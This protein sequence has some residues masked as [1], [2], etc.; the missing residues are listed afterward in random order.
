M[1]RK[2]GLSYS[3]IRKLSRSRKPPR[4]PKGTPRNTATLIRAFW[5]I[6]K[7]EKLSKPQFE[8]VRQ[9]R[10]YTKGKPRTKAEAELREHYSDYLQRET[11]AAK[12]RGK[13]IPAVQ[14][15]L[16][17]RNAAI[18]RGENPDLIRVYFIPDSQGPHRTFTV[19]S[20]IRFMAR[21]EYKD[22][23]DRMLAEGI[24]VLGIADENTND[25]NRV[26]VPLITGRG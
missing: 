2:T 24:F 3:V 6:V 16:R 7:G 12:K 10:G 14:N 20:W 19:T 1:K 18:K 4:I 23:R 22:P 9:W 17:E 13:D 5:K 11:R 21:D 26:L 15:A 25:I 8:R